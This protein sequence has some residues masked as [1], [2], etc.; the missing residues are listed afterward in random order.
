MVNVADERVLTA[1]ALSVDRYRHRFD[2]CWL[3]NA[4]AFQR[5]RVCRK[6]SA[7]LCA[8]VK[9]GG[10]WGHMITPSHRLSEPKWSGFCWYVYEESTYYVSDF[11]VSEVERDSMGWKAHWDAGDSVDG[12][13]TRLN[14]N[15]I[16]KQA[17]E[18]RDSIWDQKTTAKT[19]AYSL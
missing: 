5:Y 14:D 15:R 2:V 1:W 18:W 16:S 13:V 12:R 8:T 11:S 7:L 17:H 3:S 19:E 6:F 9:S 10:D 4:L